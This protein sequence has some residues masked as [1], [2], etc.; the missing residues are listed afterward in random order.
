[1]GV[2]QPGEERAATEPHRR[3]DI[4]RADVLDAARG[5]DGDADAPLEPRAGPRELRLQHGG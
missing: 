4:E 5:V 2:H 1:V 3:L